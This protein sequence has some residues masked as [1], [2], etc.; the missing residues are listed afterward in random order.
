MTTSTATTFPS[1][2]PRIDRLYKLLPSIYRIR[3]AEQN[4]PL[5]ALLRV[6][7]EQVNVVEDDILQLYDNWFIETA[8]PWAVPYIADLIGYTPVSTAGLTSVRGTKRTQALAEILVPRREVANTIRYRRRKGTLLLLEDLAYDVAGWPARA[9]EF[10]KHLGW[11]QNIDHPHME[12]GHTVD[13]RLLRELERLNGPFDRMAHTVDIR[14]IDSARTVGRTNIPSVGVFVWRLGSYS[15]TRCPAYCAEE[16]GPHCMTFSLLGQDAPLFIDP[17]E[18]QTPGEVT[19]EL[20]VPIAIRRTEFLEQKADLYGAD[21][22][23]CIWAEGWN[24]LDADTPVPIDWIVPA[25]LSGWQY[26]PWPKTVAL[27]PHTGRFAFPP[28]QLPKKG[29]RVTYHYGFSAGIG[30]GE[31]DRPIFNPAQRVAADST[32]PPFSLY[33]VGRDQTFHRIGDA[34]DQWKKDAPVDAVIELTDTTVYVEPIYVTL[35]E[36]QTLQLRA[37]NRTRPVIRLL[38]W[39]S[40]LPDALSVTMGHGSRFTLDGLLITGRAVQI[41]GAGDEPPQNAALPEC[42][43]EVVI[44]HCTLVPGWGIDCDCNAKRPAEPSLE[45]YNVRARVRVEHSILGAI[46]VNENSVTYDPI[47][48]KL[49]DSI[50]DAVNPQGRAIGVPGGDGPAYAVLTIQRC[51]AFG[52]VD[53]HAIQLAENSIF[54]SCVNVARRQLGCMRFCY[55]PAGCRTP[56]RYHCK[57]D[58]VIQQ[59]KAEQSNLALQAAD[60]AAEK[61][62]VQPQFT[63][64]HYGSPTYAQLALTCAPE[65][66]AGA[67]DESEMGAFHDLFQPQRR[68]NLQARLEQFTPAGMDVGIIW[69]N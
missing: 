35:N 43:A 30:G 38:D 26:V 64:T 32:P 31:Y 66:L 19:T 15:V 21:K 69:G 12:R 1:T 25:D 67:D 42:S 18:G 60:I 61:L 33:R 40:D 23:V 11:N 14:R 46:Q 47:P 55:V 54:N 56:R 2:D 68:A 62:R 44:R 51:T 10:L 48:M 22:S 53:V 24:G 45:L 3:D 13:V 6:I 59:V 57:P 34:L 28:S 20:N 65:I 16:A 52:I 4:Y 58:G 5:Q 17:K 9:V 49:T 50:L 37:A 8:Q 29:C 63:S 39:Q 36:G 27:D 7:A 41:T